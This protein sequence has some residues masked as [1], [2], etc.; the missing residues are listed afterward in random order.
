MS[1]IRAIKIGQY[2]LRC[3]A[4]VVVKCTKMAVSHTFLLQLQIFSAQGENYSYI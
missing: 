1:S 3:T 4:A 2:T